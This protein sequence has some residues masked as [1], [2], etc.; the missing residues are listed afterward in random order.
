M[1][2]SPWFSVEDDGRPIR[3]GIYQWEI[4]I[5]TSVYC[6]H[7]IQTKAPFSPNTNTIILD[8]RVIKITKDDCWRG[9]VK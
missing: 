2:L 9:V 7:I 5:R 6:G 1:I 3:K 8:G 4:Y